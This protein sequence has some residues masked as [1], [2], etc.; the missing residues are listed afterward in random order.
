MPF[1]QVCGQTDMDE[2]V[3]CFVVAETPQRAVALTLEH[4]KL[5]ADDFDMDLG[6][7]EFPM[8]T[9]PEHYRDCVIE[10]HLINLTEVTP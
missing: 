4:E 1:Y 7:Y 5:T 2:P 10:D 3:D 8:V 9:L 6:V